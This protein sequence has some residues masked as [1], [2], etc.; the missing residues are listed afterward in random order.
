MKM[1]KFYLNIFC[2]AIALLTFSSCSDDDDNKDSGEWDGSTGSK[3]AYILNSGNWGD[4]DA[5]LSYFDLKT[6][7]VTTDLFGKSNKG[8]LLGDVAQDVI[9]YGSKLYLTVTESNIIYILDKE[10][11]ILADSIRP[12]N[13]SGQPLKPRNLLAHDGKVYV[14][15]YGGFV[16]RIDTTSLKLEAKVEVGPYPEHLTV[17]NN[18]L[19][20]ATASYT[21]HV[22]EVISVIDVNQFK[23]SEEK[24]V[25]MNPNEIVV[26]A[27]GN[28][29]VACW[30]DYGDV[31]SVVKKIDATGKVTE[32]RKGNHIAIDNSNLYIVYTSS[33]PVTWKANKVEMAW[34]DTNKGELHDESFLKATGDVASDL[35]NTQSFAIDPLNKAF[36]FLTAASGANGDIHV[37]S[38]TGNYA[39]TFDTGGLFP[40]KVCFST[41]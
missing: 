27:K 3:G 41:K 39:K 13:E 9:L 17:A 36:F 38:S 18:K 19:Y 2:A 20:V 7:A 10:G 5:M 23:T 14:T 1:N 11:K 16:G 30:G 35:D 6:G 32:I 24:E 33:D 25:G 8:R 34:Y 31:K 37:F 15:L 28:V 12:L 21:P 26:D 29:Y 40:I 4:N 22:S